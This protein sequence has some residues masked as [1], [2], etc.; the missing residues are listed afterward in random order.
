MAEQGL[1]LVAKGAVQQCFAADDSFFVDQILGVAVERGGIV[2][3]D[4]DR[5]RQRPGYGRVADH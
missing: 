1:K 2:L 3:G 4:T 5:R